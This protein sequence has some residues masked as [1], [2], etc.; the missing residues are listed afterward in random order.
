MIYNHCVLSAKREYAVIVY[1]YTCTASILTYC[2]KPTT[3]VPMYAYA[4]ALLVCAAPLLSEYG[5][6]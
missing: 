1:F 3:T 2:A 5:K 6:T 4:S